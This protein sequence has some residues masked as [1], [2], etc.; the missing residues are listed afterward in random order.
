M[1]APTSLSDGV[2]RPRVLDCTIRDGG[3]I[4][5]WRFDDGFVRRVMH[6]L[7]SAGVDYME[8]GYRSSAK[9]VSPAGCGAWRFCHEDDLRRI[10]ADLEPELKL[11]VMADVGRVELADICPRRQSAVQMIRVACYAAQVEQGIELAER[12]VDLGYEA[13]INVMAISSVGPPELAK[14]LELLGRSSVPTV[15]LVDSYGALYPEQVRALIG[16]YASSLPG[17]QL[18]VHIH[19]NLQLALANTI[20]A[21][22]GGATLLDATIY[23]MGRGAGN[24]PLELLLAFLGGDVRPILDVIQDVFLPLQRELRWGY[25]APHMITG[26]LNQH[27]RRG[28]EAMAQESPPRLRQLYEE[29]RASGAPS[30]LTR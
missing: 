11:S 10:A 3:L 12:C 22:S 7:A 18:G 21:A 1:T 15:Y 9:Y 20:E 6:A 29:L 28:L 13:T 27:P 25:H 26:A 19:N 14:A 30:G 23:G 17:K 2:T 4:N 8:V 24:C 5:G 16:Q